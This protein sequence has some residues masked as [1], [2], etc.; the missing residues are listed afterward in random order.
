MLRAN[1][2]VEVGTEVVWEILK[3]EKTP[4]AAGREHDGQG[5]RGLRAARA[6]G[7]TTGS[8]STRCPSQLPI[9]E[10]ETFHGIV[11][12]IEN[13]AFT[14]SG[15]GM[16]EKSTEVPIP[17][18]L[19]A[20][21]AEARATLLEEAATGDEQLMEKFLGDRRADGRGDPPAACASASCRATWCRRSAARRT[22]TT[23]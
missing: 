7:C 1:A 9:G 17:D 3:Q 13:K 16:E 8:A 15:K 22:T 20:A 11:D 2:G 6:L 19:K 18:D 23:A 4:D 21:V 5:A 10:A 14:F 12:L